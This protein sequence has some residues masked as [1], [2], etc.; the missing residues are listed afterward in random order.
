MQRHECQC[1]ARAVTLLTVRLGHGPLPGLWC[2][3]LPCNRIYTIRYHLSALVVSNHDCSGAC[4]MVQCGMRRR[5]VSKSPVLS[6]RGVTCICDGDKPADRDTRVID[7]SHERLLP[8]TPF[9]CPSLRS[10]HVHVHVSGAVAQ[11]GFV[12]SE[13]SPSSQAALG[14]FWRP[15]YLNHYTSFRLITN[16]VYTWHDPSHNWSVSSRY[17]GVVI[18]PCPPSPV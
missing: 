5:T 3:C 2:G 8:N 16:G 4:A 14:R 6:A 15:H 11:C 18:L 10:Q 13:S 17:R 9:S 7:G 1:Q 12:C